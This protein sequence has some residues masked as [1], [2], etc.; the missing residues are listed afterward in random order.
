VYPHLPCPLQIW[1]Y[2]SNEAMTCE[3]PPTL[4]PASS[5][6]Q[7]RQIKVWYSYSWIL[8]CKLWEL[9]GFKLALSTRIKRYK[10]G[11]IMKSWELINKPWDIR[12]WILSTNLEIS[13]IGY[14]RQTLRYPMLETRE[15]LASLAPYLGY[16]I[17]STN[18]EISDIG[19]ERVLS[20]PSTIFRILDII[21]KPW[22]IR[23][24]RREST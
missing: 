16:W 24:W 9:G 12:Y 1:Y 2:K 4:P 19:D 14:Y 23:Y 3:T 11:V 18:L 20:I 5:A 21:D 17:L 8:S 10:S 15:Y 7:T 22:D 13:D 6:L